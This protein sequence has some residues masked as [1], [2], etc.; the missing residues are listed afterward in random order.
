MGTQELKDEMLQQMKSPQFLVVAALF[1]LFELVIV[2]GIDTNSRREEMQ[3]HWL[4]LYFLILCGL[5]PV[6]FDAKLFFRGGISDD[7]TD[8]KSSML[9]GSSAFISWIFAKSITNASKKGGSYGIC[10]G[11]GYAAWYLSFPSAAIVCYKLRQKGY[12]SLPQAIHAKYGTC[13]VLCF[14]ICVIYRLYNEVWS[15]SRVIADFY[16]RETK[17]YQDADGHTTTVDASKPWWAAAVISTV[18][19]LTYVF[20]GGMRSSLL[21][22]SAQAILAVVTLVVVLVAIQFERARNADL[23]HFA[24]SYSHWSLFE[25]QPNPDVSMLS[26]KGGMDMFALGAIQGGLSYAFFDPVLTDR[27]FLAAPKTMAR[28]FTVGGF[29]AAWFITLFSIIGVHG[30]MLGKCV[31]AVGHTVL[32]MEPWHAPA[33]LTRA[34]CIKEVYHWQL[35]GA[36]FDVVMSSAQQAAFEAALVNDFDSIQTSLSKVDVRT[37][38]CRNAEDTE[39]I[40]G[41]L[42]Q[43]VGFVACNTQVIGLLREAL[44][45][46]ARAALARLPAAQR[47]TST[48]INNLGLLLQQMGKP[49]EARRPAPPPRASAAPT[50]RA[51][52]RRRGAPRQRKGRRR[53]RGR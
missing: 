42:E 43:G 44:G 37:A 29:A 52:P 46:Q 30:S 11:F 17:N 25:W 31:S 16:G 23:R 22:D 33:P 19:P 14:A 38:T 28:C 27:C 13:A 32:L 9:V 39:A 3:W 36:Q 51:A 6:T 10:G 20:C 18:L 53:E 49:E 15:N 21:S 8:A 1:V 41:E 5:T 2:F 4:S 50:R 40:L 45:A 12:K 35:S 24:K 47:G 48:L 34:Y 26:L 7:A